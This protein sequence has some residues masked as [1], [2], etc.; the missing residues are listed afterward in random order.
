VLAEHRDRRA[1][2]VTHGYL[3]YD[4]QRYD[5]RQGKQ[6]ATPYGYAGDGADG[7]QLWNVVARRNPNVMIVICGHVRTGGLGY[8]KSEGDYGNTVHEMMANYQ[9]LPAGGLGYMRLLEFQPDRKTVQV[10]TF[11]PS[12]K[13]LRHS[14]LE[15]FSFVLQNATRAEPKRVP[16]DAAPLRVAPVHRY[17]FDGEGGDGTKVK[18]LS[19]DLDGALKSPDGSARLDGEGHLVIDRSDGG[20]LVELSPELLKGK[21]RTSMEIWLTPTAEAYKWHAVTYFGDRA[22]AFYYTFRTLTKHRAELIDD[23]H[24]EDIQRDVAVKVGEPMH[25]VMTYDQGGGKKPAV[26]TSFIDGEM[27]GSMNT[28]IQLSDLDL[29]HAR[30]GPF[31]GVYDELRIYDYALSPHEVRNNFRQGPDVVDLAGDDR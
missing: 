15:D 27:N 12:L 9:K 22:D 19:G 23:G 10:R 20:G 7:E 1:I 25:I 17:S 28:S 4:N 5:H 21:R 30:I 3:F 26:I 18:D 11:S 29:K 2:I 16:A 24:N 14:E 13:K 8:R 6:R 31:A